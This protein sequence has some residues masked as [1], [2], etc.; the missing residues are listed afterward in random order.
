MV[1]R[2]EYIRKLKSQIDQWNAEAAKWEAKAKQAQA[3][4]QAEYAK[5]LEQFRARRDAATAELKRLQ[6]A[7]A[8]AWQDM[9]KGADAALKSMQEAFDRARRNFEKK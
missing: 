9:M 8:D 5:Q 2:D 3:G 4:M 7:S 1:N 6:G